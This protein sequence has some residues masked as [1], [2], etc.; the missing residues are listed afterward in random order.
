MQIMPN[1]L[2]SLKIN[3]YNS[4]N[5]N[6]SAGIKYLAQVKRMFSDIPEDQQHYF[7]VAAYNVG[8]GHIKDARKLAEEMGLNSEEWV[9]VEKVLS[10]LMKEE[11]YSKTRHGYCRAT[12][13]IGYVKN[14]MVY[15]EILKER[16]QDL[17]ETPDSVEDDEAQSS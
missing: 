2:K 17:L 11:Y 1:T 9:N 4:I 7:T 8:P 3:D 10:L 15:Y 6:I 16:N 14:I 5:G 13:T 12:E